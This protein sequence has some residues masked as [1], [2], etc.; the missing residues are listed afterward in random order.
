MAPARGA[1]PVAG[2][3][4]DDAQ[5]PGAERR[6][7]TKAG[8]GSM[9]L[10]ECLLDGI[11]GVGLRADEVRGPTRDVLIPA[12]EFLVR[13]DVATPGSRDGFVVVDVDGPPRSTVPRTPPKARR[14][15]GSRSRRGPNGPGM[16][17]PRPGQAMTTG[18]D[19]QMRMYPMLRS[20]TN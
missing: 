19:A 14:F 18:T 17:H 7:G 15:P 5:K 16:A 9:G 3:V 2:L 1:T 13:R 12:D 20:W 10:E 11:V 6:P 4:R 8:E